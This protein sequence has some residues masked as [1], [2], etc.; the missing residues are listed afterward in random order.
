MVT[1]FCLAK[2]QSVLDVDR[3][4]PS[5]RVLEVPKYCSVKL[6]TDETFVVFKTYNI[7]N[8]VML[9]HDFIL[10]ENKRAFCHCVVLLLAILNRS[11]LESITPITHF[12]ITLED[13]G[14]LCEK[15]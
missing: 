12:T 5:K 6:S 7:L 11:S 10:F 1:S 2:G 14:E 8:C 13:N 3:K 9:L 4:L 15:C